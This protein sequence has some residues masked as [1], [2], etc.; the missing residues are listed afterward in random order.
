MANNNQQGQQKPQKAKPKQSVSMIPKKVTNNTLEVE[1]IV[2][3]GSKGMSNVDIVMSVDGLVIPGSL[4]TDPNGRALWIYQFTSTTQS[5][6]IRAEAV[7]QDSPAK[8][9]T[10]LIPTTP[11][12]PAQS[13]VTV[14]PIL[15][16]EDN[17]LASGKWRL[18]F[19]LFANGQAVAGRVAFSPSK[20]LIVEGKQRNANPFSVQI[21]ADKWARITIEFFGRLEIDVFVEGFPVKKELRFTGPPVPQS[22]PKADDFFGNLTKDWT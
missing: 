1:V 5:I 2:L 13:K 12:V 20:A 7:I 18:T 4:K 8:E 17:E 14:I 9:L 16:I 19:A 15:V 3:D 6:R 22:P 21:K 10:I 11:A